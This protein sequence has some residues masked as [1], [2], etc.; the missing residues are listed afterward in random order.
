MKVPPAQLL[1][2]LNPHAKKVDGYFKDEWGGVVVSEFCGLKPK[3]YAIK[4]EFA[5]YTKKAKGVPKTALKKLISMEDYKNCIFSMD[6]EKR[7]KKVQFTKLSSH[8]HAM[9]VQRKTM[10]ALTA[11]DT[12]RWICDDNINTLAYG[13][14][15]ITELNM[16]R[17]EERLNLLGRTIVAIEEEKDEMED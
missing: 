13:H 10:L 14:Y 7:I 1:E 3:C 12:K 11:Y 4:D 9:Y 8:R 15:R 6:K 17:A 16:E 2:G 5:S